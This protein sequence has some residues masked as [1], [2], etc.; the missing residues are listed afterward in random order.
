MGHFFLRLSGKGK[1]KLFYFWPKS[2]KCDN[3]QNIQRQNELAMLRIKNGV[4][5]LTIQAAC[6]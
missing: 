3:V 4:L 5:P 1:Q 2:V 6:N